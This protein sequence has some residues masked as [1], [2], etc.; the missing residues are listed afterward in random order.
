MAWPNKSSATSL[1]GTF[2]VA[3]KSSRCS[4][5]VPLLF[6]I[7][8]VFI[9]IYFLHSSFVLFLLRQIN[10]SGRCYVCA[11]ARFMILSTAI[12]RLL[13]QRKRRWRYFM[14]NEV[15][16][17]SQLEPPSRLWV[18][19]RTIA[20]L[21]GLGIVFSL[22]FFGCH[23]ILYIYRIC[24]LFSFGLSRLFST[25]ISCHWSWLDPFHYQVV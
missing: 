6:R 17:T 9:F 3:E 15:L 12:L 4:T 21:T 5:T 16:F 18:T 25:F 8:V 13:D 14:W 22:S 7:V 24:Y 20:S 23:F 1:K 10:C 2:N 19:I 11:P